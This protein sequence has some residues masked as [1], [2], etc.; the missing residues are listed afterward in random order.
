MS[1]KSKPARPRTY[2]GAH[3][4]YDEY[5]SRLIGESNK[6]TRHAMKMLTNFQPRPPRILF[7]YTNPSG[8]LGILQTNAFWATDIR[9]M[10]DATELSYAIE[11]FKGLLDSESGD[12]DHQKFF[13]KIISD[14]F[15]TLRSAFRLY[16]VSFSEMPDDLTQWKA[17]GGGIGGYA[18]GFRFSYKGLGRFMSEAGFQEEILLA[19]VLYDRGIQTKLLKNL[20]NR[21]RDTAT[22]VYQAYKRGDF[23]TCTESLLEGLASDFSSHV[24]IPVADCLI[25][26]KHPKFSSEREWRIIRYIIDPDG[27]TGDGNLAFPRHYRIGKGGLC[28]YVELRIPDRS[29]PTKHSPKKLLPINTVW[30]GPH[31]EPQLFSS[32]MRECLIAFGYA[33]VNVLCSK[34]PTR[35]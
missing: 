16:A 25:R 11:M 24:V 32:L 4:N 5:I 7:H 8:A 30:Q 22:R 34:V 18:I 14:V 3:F 20:I 12:R 33:D 26:I 1:K 6:V 27:G 35:F 13:D 9:F 23:G 2:Q 19:K 21:L 15:E 28:P 29:S 10:N 17:Y 31:N